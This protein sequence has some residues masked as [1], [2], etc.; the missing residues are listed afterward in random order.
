MV[1]RA[2]PSK[3]SGESGRTNS[4]DLAAKAGTDGAQSAVGCP[5]RNSLIVTQNQSFVTLHH[6]ARQK[7]ICAILLH[8]G[9]GEADA[10]TFDEGDS[11]ILEERL[12]AQIDVF[13]FCITLHR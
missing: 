5:D 9:C 1:P 3:I 11:H 6:L 12:G 8:L 10:V 13:G 2:H 7:E 4:R